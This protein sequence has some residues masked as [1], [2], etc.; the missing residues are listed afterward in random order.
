MNIYKAFA[1]KDENSKFVL[2]EIKAVDL[3]AA[4]AWF[5]RN[6]TEFETILEIINN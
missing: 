3:A 6:T 2:T 4:R 1:K 5:K